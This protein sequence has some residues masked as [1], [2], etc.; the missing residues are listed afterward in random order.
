MAL[1]KQCR[2]GLVGVGTEGDIQKQ[3]RLGL[4]GAGVCPNR[5]CLSLRKRTPTEPNRM[6]KQREHTQQLTATGNFTLKQCYPHCPFLSLKTAAAASS[7]NTLKAASN[8]K[9][10]SC[11]CAASWTRSAQAWSFVGPLLWRSQSLSGPL[12]RPT[13][14]SGPSKD[15]V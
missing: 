10:G 4:V 6:S 3:C 13:S 8:S 15:L 7:Q 11:V 12:R 5:V 14:G 9:S 1:R 2:L